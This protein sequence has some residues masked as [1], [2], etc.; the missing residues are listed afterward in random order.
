MKNTIKE[1]RAAELAA[2]KAAEAQAARQAELDAIEPKDIV[3][4]MDEVVEGTAHSYRNEDGVAIGTNGGQY[5]QVPVGPNSTIA[6]SS[7]E[8]IEAIKERMDRGIQGDGMLHKV[9]RIEGAMNMLC[10]C[11]GRTEEELNADIKAAE[12]YAKAHGCHIIRDIDVA[13]QL[14]D[15]EYTKED[16]EQIEVYGITY[17][18][19]YSEKR[20]MD[21]QGNTVESLD[22]YTSNFTKEDVKSLLVR[23]LSERVVEVEDEEYDD[24]YDEDDDYYDEDEYDEDEDY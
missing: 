13:E 23:L 24:E 8:E 21:L 18:I 4:T 6:A 17:L 3:A 9:L 11:C 16:L 14:V 7:Q 5:I 12:N 1:N 2:K 22:G 10:D 20:A 19:S 15:A